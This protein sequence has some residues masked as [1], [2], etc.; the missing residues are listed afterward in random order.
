MAS[1]NKFTEPEIFRR[2]EA[3]LLAQ[4]LLIKETALTAKGL[5]LPKYPTKENMPYDAIV[6][7]FLSPDESLNDLYDA[8]YLIGR[9]ASKS[10]RGA[11]FAVAKEAGIKIPRTLSSNYDLAIWLWLN[12]PKQAMHAGYRLKMHN[13]RSF[14]YFSSYLDAQAPEPQ[15]TQANIDR[16]AKRMASY[17]SAVSKG[18]AVK[19]FDVAERDE[20]W[21]LIR[22]GGHLERRGDVDNKTGEVETV[23]FRDEEY[24]VVI[25]NTRHRELKIRHATDSTIE[26]LKLEF[27]TV[28]FGTLHTFVKREVFPLQALRETDLTFLRKVKVPGIR[29][30]KLSEVR[31]ALP[32]CVTKTVHEKSADLIQASNPR[33]PIIPVDAFNVEFAKLKFLFE[34]ERTGRSVDLYPPNKSNFARESDAPRVETWLRD[35][36]LMLGG[37]A[38]DPHVRFMK[39]LNIHLGKTYTMNEWKFLFGEIFERIEPYLRSTGLTADFWCDPETMQHRKILR[40]NGKIK[41]LSPDYANSPEL[42][43]QVEEEDIQLYC[44]CPETFAGQLCQ[45]CGVEPAF[46]DYGDGVYRLGTFRGPD[47]KRYPAILSVHAERSPLSLAKQVTGQEGDAVMFI[48]PGYCPDTAEFARQKKTLYVPME[49]HLQDDLSVC[50]TFDD[51]RKQFFNLQAEKELITKDQITSLFLLAQKLDDK[52]RLKA[53]THLTV[54]QLYCIKSMS[55]DEIA[56]E[57]GCSKGTVASRKNTLDAKLGCDLMEFRPYSDHLENIAES[58]SD[59]RAK[60]YNGH[61][62]IYDDGA[63]DE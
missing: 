19:I 40:E 35:A 53:P 5:L 21:L 16:F 44:L 30:V 51:A 3:A 37:S 63:Y 49:D 18:G 32:G 33:E 47:R 59:D 20:Q 34:G 9:L 17:Y 41:A 13:T 7:L 4:L 56:E 27:G 15:F 42:E 60:G 31:Y 36:G 54:L 26:R 29:E 2:F 57:C 45:R 52:P 23:C 22:H 48:S 58:L 24:D 55:L 12:H 1:L 28:F 14:H 61:A 8:V 11:I 38:D 39:I 43:R 25:Y 50:E 10:G 6:Q 62:A 46:K